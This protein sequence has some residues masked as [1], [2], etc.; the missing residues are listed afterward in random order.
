MKKKVV[1]LGLAVVLSVSMSLTAF[2]AGSSSTTN[3]SSTTTSNSSSQSSS[4]QSSSSQSSSSES[5]SSGTSTSRPAP[6]ANT[7]EKALP[8]GAVA[9]ATVKVAV[10]GANGQVSAVSLDT[11]VAAT[12]Q[13]IVASA[14]TAQGA[15]AS[16]QSLLTRGASP[17]FMQTVAAL[18]EIKG[19]SMVVNNAGTLKTAAAVKDP[20]GNTIA[21]AGTI[22]NVTA[23]SLVMLMSVNADGT[24]EYVEGVVD[25]V[26][27]LIMGV[28]QGTPSVITVLVLA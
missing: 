2:A 4:S 11:V 24:V 8:G 28:F 6:A 19:S 15:V 1:A 13:N 18:A 12:T 14:T 22:K 3:N 21:A 10:A 27:G 23:G 5:S 25:P 17:I 20:L 26:T 9:P 7:V 16:V